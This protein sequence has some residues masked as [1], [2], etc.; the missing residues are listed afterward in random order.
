[1]A[2]LALILFVAW[3]VVV[4]AVPT[5]ARAGR[6]GGPAVRFRDRPRSAQWWAR[7]LST[8]GVVSGLAAPIADLAGLAAIAFLDH[9]TVAVAGLI[10]YGLGV[11]GTLYGQ[12][13]MG[14]SWRGDVDPEV[15]TELVTTG[16][17][18]I[19]RN[20][21]LTATALTVLGLVLLVPNVLSLVMLAAVVTALHIQVRLVEEPYLLRVHGEAYRRYAERTGRFLPGIGR[22]PPPAGGDD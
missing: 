7:V 10:L 4:V 14:A 22:W 15:R 8:V 2:V 20:P 6:S 11:A 13:A 12:A 21:I 17:F 9:V 19:V 18:R 5:I 3:I 1:M 16:P